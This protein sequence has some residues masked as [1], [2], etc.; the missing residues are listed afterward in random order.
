MA[1]QFSN[2]AYNLAKIQR[3]AEQNVQQQIEENESRTAPLLRQPVNRGV[4]DQAE[5]RARA[6]VERQSSSR[7]AFLTQE[8]LARRLRP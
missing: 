3:D 5:S 4:A 8:E 7:P 2:A 6:A 1:N